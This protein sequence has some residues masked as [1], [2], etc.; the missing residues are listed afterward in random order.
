MRLHLEC[1]HKED[2]EE[3]LSEEKN[4]DD[5]KKK[6]N[7]PSGSGIAGYFKPN[8]SSD[9]KSPKHHKRNPYPEKTLIYKKFKTDLTRLAGFT[10]STLNMMDSTQFKELLF[11]LNSRIADS[12]PS[13]NTL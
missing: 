9:G 12:L 2:M 6:P 1:H 7:Q 13:R 3:L 11:D 8:Q 5:C 10:S 4:I